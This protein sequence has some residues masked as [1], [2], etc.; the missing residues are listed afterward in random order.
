VTGDSKVL[1]GIVLNGKEG[2]ITVKGRTYNGSMP[3]LSMLNDDQIANILTYIRL[4]FN[5]DSTAITSEEVSKVRKELK[6]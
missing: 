2:E 5:N 3:E 1:I 4:R 6:K